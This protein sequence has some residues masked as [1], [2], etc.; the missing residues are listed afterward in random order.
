[1]KSP[2]TDGND[3]RGVAAK[4]SG[5]TQ[6]DIANWKQKGHHKATED[7]L[8]TFGT[9]GMGTVQKLYE[10]FVELNRGDVAEI[11]EE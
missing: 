11:L 1:M 6:Q 10:I 7:T 4:I 3:W 9:S 2:C 8:Q 5:V